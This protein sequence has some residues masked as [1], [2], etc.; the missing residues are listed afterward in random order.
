MRP[1]EQA[2]DR[3]E[4]IPAQARAALKRRLLDPRK[5]ANADDHLLMTR[6]GVVGEAGG[7]RVQDMNRGAGQVCWGEVTRASWAPGQ[8]ERAL[9]FCEEGWC[10]AYFS[11]CRNI[12]TAVL[13]EPKRPAA[14]L[15]AAMPLG[16]EDSWETVA[17][18]D[19][20]PVRWLKP[21]PTPPGEVTPPTEPPADDD[22]R[23]PPV[24]FRYNPLL[25]PASGVGLVVAEFNGVPV[26]V[27]PIPEPGTW[28]LMLVGLAAVVG[29]A[30]RG[31]D[32]ATRDTRAHDDR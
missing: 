2:V 26:P 30:R 7:W 9:V 21:E 4:Y 3:L 24:V 11:V 14:G 23:W 22:W 19:L 10:V 5:H 8:A 27:T 6:D 17:Q 29:W 12:A 16:L 20:V 25:P 32:K 18:M 13:V 1:L 31:H 15:G 28:A